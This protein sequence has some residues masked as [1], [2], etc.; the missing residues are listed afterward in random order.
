MGASFVSFK[1]KG[2]QAD[3]R[4]RFADAQEQDRYENGHSYSG[5]IGM[6]SGLRFVASSFDDE[7]NAEDWL[8]DHAQKWE[9]ALAVR[10]NGKPD[11][12]VIGAWCSS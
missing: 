5:G 9:E 7:K 8:V 6:A 3:I 4:R 2:A 10:L 11:E 12:Y 1:M